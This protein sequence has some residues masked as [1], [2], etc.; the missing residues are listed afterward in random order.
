MYDLE[1]HRPNIKEYLA[2]LI[3][4]LI[5]S[6]AITFFFENLARGLVTDFFSTQIA[7]FLLIVI[8][9]PVIEEY[10]K[11]Y[12]L[13]RRHSETAR[14][15]IKLGFCSGLGFGISEFIVY[16]FF[17]GVP[18]YIRLPGLL[19]HAASTSITAS[20][21]SKNQFLRFYAIAVILHSINNFFAEL[22]EVWFIG[23]LG[24]V[25]LTYIFAYR[26]LSSAED[27]YTIDP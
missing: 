8:L 11:V 9:A 19:F 20:G 18:S 23:G 26:Q 10:T 1:I 21:I 24:T 15:L 22:G 14:S 12:P 17:A 7:G 6:V 27:E 3:Q 13:F 25:I 5:T 4:G 16:V 2:Y